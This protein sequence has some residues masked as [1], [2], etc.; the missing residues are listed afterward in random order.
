MKTKNSIL[1]SF[2]TAPKRLGSPRANLFIALSVLAALF[3]LQPAH[4]QES[5]AGALTKAEQQQMQDIMK[6]VDEKIKV[7]FKGQEALQTE[8]SK[9]LQRISG[10]KDSAEQ[11]RAAATYQAKYLKSYSGVLSKAGVDLS[12]VAKQLQGVARRFNFSVLPDLSIVGIYA[13]K[14]SPLALPP[15]GPTSKTT[16]I[17]QFVD[18]KERSCSLAAG[19]DVTFTSSSATTSAGAVVAGGCSSRGDKRATV[20]VPAAATSALVSVRADLAAEAFAVGVLGTSIADA[21]ASFAVNNSGFASVFVVVVAPI[22][23]IASAEESLDGQSINVELAA[24]SSNAV[25]FNTRAI[26]IAAIGGGSSKAKV[27]NIAASLTVTQ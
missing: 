3:S 10:L 13:K 15:A 5:N 20:A 24:G 8:M 22:A 2:V 9:E 27:K 21:S 7:G 23:W 17:D 12:T 16:K 19:S 25:R 26:V 18:H 6:K 11:K 1:T 14:S 4:A